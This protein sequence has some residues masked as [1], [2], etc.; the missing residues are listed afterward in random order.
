VVAQ[1]TAISGD[2]LLVLPKAVFEQAGLSPIKAAA[3][4]NLLHPP[5]ETYPHR[6]GSGAAMMGNGMLGPAHAAEQ[7]L[8]S[9]LCTMLRNAADEVGHLAAIAHQCRYCWRYRPPQ[10]SVSF[11]LPL[12]QKRV[13]V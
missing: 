3:I 12:P 13:F 4:F 9:M 7:R 10:P 11:P 5:P 6:G 8:G 2:E 1:F